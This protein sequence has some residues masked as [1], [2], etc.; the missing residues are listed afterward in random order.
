[1]ICA[2]EEFEKKSLLNYFQIY[3]DFCL[4]DRSFVTSHK[5]TK[6][7][8]AVECTCPDGEKYTVAKTNDLAKN[9]ASTESFCHGGQVTKE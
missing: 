4:D 5:D 6:S 1:M 2:V 3:N 8:V 9:N 7:S